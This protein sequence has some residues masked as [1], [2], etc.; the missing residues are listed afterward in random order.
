MLG[1]VAGTFAVA[2]FFQ[3]YRRLFRLLQRDP[4]YRPIGAKRGWL[5]FYQIANTVSIFV[6]AAFIIAGTAQHPPKPRLMGIAPS[7]LLLLVCTFLLV[8]IGLARLG[9][10]TPFRFSSLPKGAVMRPGVYVMVEDV[11]AVDAGVGIVYR[12]ALNARYEASPHF[13][14]MLAKLNLFWAVGGECAGIII[15]GLCYIKEL[16]DTAAFGIGRHT[17]IQPSTYGRIPVLLIIHT[18]WVLP[19]IWAAIWAIITIKWVQADLKK[20]KAACGNKIMG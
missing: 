7:I 13:R 6:T 14:R 18:G 15:I 19:F 20:E 4:K 12:E 16:G 2:T 5:D 1:V 9:F 17:L 8:F 3:Y 11:I 10:R